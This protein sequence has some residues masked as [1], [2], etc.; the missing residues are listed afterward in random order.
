MLRSMRG[1]MKTLGTETPLY[2][3]LLP[4]ARMRASFSRWTFSSVLPFADLPFIGSKRAEDKGGEDWWTRWWREMLT[5]SP[6]LGTVFEQAT[7]EDSFTG[8]KIVEDDM[9]TVETL[10]ASGPRP[11]WATGCHLD[12]W[13]G[14][15]CRHRPTPPAQ[16]CLDT[17]NWWQSYLRALVGLDALRRS[18]DAPRG[19]VFSREAEAAAAGAGEFATRLKSR[20]G[21]QIKG[22]LI[23]DE[24]DIDA[25]AEALARLEASGNP[26]ARPN[27]WPN[28]WTAWTR[29]TDQRS[30]APD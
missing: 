21:S 28:C 5:A 1:K 20:L 24:P 9:G 3:F 2:A 25:I 4:C 29:A 26:C 13:R 16:Q 22:E 18:A 6:V 30:F 14:R 12:A 10:W 15:A 19:G 7:N 11:C 23:Q 8:K 17:R 27:K